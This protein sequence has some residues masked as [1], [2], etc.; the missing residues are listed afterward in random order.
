MAIPAGARI[1]EVNNSDSPSPMPVE[2]GSTSSWG[3][4]QI[5]HEQGETHR[6]RSKV[7]EGYRSASARLGGRRSGWNPEVEPPPYHQPDIF[8]DEKGQRAGIAPAP[9]A[10]PRDGDEEADQLDRQADDPDD[11][12]MCW[13][14]D[15]TGG[16]DH[17]IEHEREDG[18]AR[19][20]P[21]QQHA[22]RS[23]ARRRRSTGSPAPPPTPSV[24]LTRAIPEP[25]R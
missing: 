17:G 14:A 15:G 23:F 3:K 10:T 6:D 13:L 8:T 1:S 19:G 9:L 12:Q 22:S 20:Y 16:H 7:G 5:P 11:V 25:S 24:A 4:H 21:E 2:V 18:D